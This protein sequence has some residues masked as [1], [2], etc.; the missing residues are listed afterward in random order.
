ML[1]AVVKFSVSERCAMRKLATRK[2]VQQVLG[3]SQLCKS[4]LRC[5]A[6]MLALGHK[7]K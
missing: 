7:S 3:C 4:Q 1:I 5:Y 2:G 6:N